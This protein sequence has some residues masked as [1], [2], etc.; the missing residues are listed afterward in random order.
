[1]T[2]TTK[3]DINQEVFI[4][5]KGKILEGRVYR[6]EPR[7]KGDGDMY[8]ANITCYILYDIDCNGEI[9]RGINEKNIC[10]TKKEAICG[11]V[12]QNGYVVPEDCLI[13]IR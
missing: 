2:I 8:I 6:I 11:M 1:M 9:Y 10:K 4:I 3:Y 5:E 13:E 7:V 12:Q